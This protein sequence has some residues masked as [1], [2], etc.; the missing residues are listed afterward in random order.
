[1]LNSFRKDILIIDMH[2][3]NDFLNQRGAP[4]EWGYFMN[5]Y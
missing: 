4:A 5:T 1:M 2:Q 3:E